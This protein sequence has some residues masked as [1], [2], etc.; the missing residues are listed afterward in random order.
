MV[1]GIDSFAVTNIDG[2]DSVDVIRV[3]IA[4]RD[5]RRAYN[6]VPNDTEILARVEPVY[7]DFPGWKQ[8]THGIRRW[9]DLP[10]R[11]RSY[12]KAIA[13]MSGAPLSIVSVGPS[14]EQTLFL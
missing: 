9:K 10:G 13:E 4:Y 8:P 12:L 11:A 14:R 6:H 5:G 7:V 3:C 2:L 1:N